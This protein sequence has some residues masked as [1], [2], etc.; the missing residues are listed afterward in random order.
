LRIGA[1]RVAP[2]A[3]AAWERTSGGVR[4][5]QA[6][7]ERRTAPGEPGSLEALRP[8][9]WT[10]AS[11]SDRLE[12][13]SVLTLL[14]E[15]D[16]ERLGLARRLAESQDRTVGAGALRAAGVLPVPAARRRPASVLDHHEEGPDG[17]FALL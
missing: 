1:G 5:L 16:A 11:T 2:V 10:R 3:P 8:A 13:I 14:G 9:R 6:W 7:W 17:Q 12:V 4:V 15:A